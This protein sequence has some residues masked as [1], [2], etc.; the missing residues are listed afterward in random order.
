[1]YVY[2]YIGTINHKKSSSIFKLNLY[3]C[4]LPNSDSV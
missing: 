2:I 3:L 4:A 1:M